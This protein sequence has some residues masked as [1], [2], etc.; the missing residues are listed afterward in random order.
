MLRAS[1]S[2]IANTP[3]AAQGAATLLN[4]VIRLHSG[5]LVVVIRDEYLVFWPPIL[6]LQR[7]SSLRVCACRLRELEP[8]E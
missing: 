4:S 8:Q 7:N 5:F 2:G 3:I 1:N 6:E